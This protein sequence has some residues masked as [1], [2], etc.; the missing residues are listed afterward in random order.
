MKFRIKLVNEHFNKLGSGNRPRHRID[1]EAHDLKDA[2]SKSYS[3]VSEF[4][5]KGGIV[6][7]GCFGSDDLSYWA[8]W[9]IYNVCKI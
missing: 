3:L 5:A 7:S 4:N 9:K 1:F 6:K 8:D 2:W